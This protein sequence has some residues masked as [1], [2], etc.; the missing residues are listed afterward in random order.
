MTSKITS[1]TWYKV[2]GAVTLADL[3]DDLR[4]HSSKKVLLTKMILSG[5]LQ[6]IPELKTAKSIAEQILA[7][8]I[9]EDGWVHST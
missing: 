8:N 3:F 4:P 9:T 7:G 5:K 1:A 2:P 6:I